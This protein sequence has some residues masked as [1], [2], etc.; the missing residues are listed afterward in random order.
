MI[1]VILSHH[2]VPLLTILLEGI[3]SNSRYL[4]VQIRCLTL[5]RNDHLVMVVMMGLGLR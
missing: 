5:V 3:V 1:S 4:M 2:S